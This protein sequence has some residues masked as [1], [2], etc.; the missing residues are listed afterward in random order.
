MYNMFFNCN[1]AR[2]LDIESNIECKGIIFDAFNLSFGHMK[3]KDYKA[4]V[5]Y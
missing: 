1:I 5:P 2:A 4:T 3:E